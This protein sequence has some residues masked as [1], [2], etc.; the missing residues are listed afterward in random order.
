MKK[1][2]VENGVIECIDLLFE[3][4]GCLVLNIGIKLQNGGYVTF[5]NTSLGNKYQKFEHCVS[6]P[7][8]PYNWA[9]YY[10]SKVFAVLGVNSITDIKKGKPIR[11]IIWDHICIG[12]QDF[13]DKTK[14]YIPREDWPENMKDI[15]LS[16]V[17]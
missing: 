5:G 12:I 1:A 10:I 7:G 3:D 6:H 16:E 2:T 4:H 9:A 13:M 17:K 8:E 15:D 11:A 14:Y